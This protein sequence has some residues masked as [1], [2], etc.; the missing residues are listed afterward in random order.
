MA[1]DAYNGYKFW[2]RRVQGAIRVGLKRNCSNLAASED[3]FFVAIDRGRCLRLDPLS[4]RTLTTYT[5]PSSSRT[6]G[7]GWGYVAY[8][9]GLLFGST[10]VRAGISDSVF[11][12]DV[13]TGDRVWSYPGST[14]MDMAIAIGDGK[15][16]F[17]ERGGVTARQ[18]GEA[19]R[20]RTEKLKRLKGDALREAQKAL[21]SADVRQVVALDATTGKTLWTK[22]IDVSNCV[23]ISSGG[24]DLTVMY[25]DKVV[26][27]CGQ[28][29]DGHFWA[30][31]FAGEFSRRS[32]I[33][34]S[35]D[36][37][38]VLWAKKAGYR[39]RPL[40]V[41]NTIIAEPWAFDLH[42]GKPKMRINPI[43]GARE[44]W[45][46]AR[47]GHHCGPM[48]AGA[49]TLAFRS[50]VVGYYDLLND[51]GPFHFGGQRPGCHINFI[52][53]NGLLLIPEGS[54]GCMCPFPT[55]C[56][57]VFEHRKKDR[58]WGGYSAKGPVKPMKHIAIN[59]GAPGDRKDAD[60]LLWLAY[61]RKSGR[62][63]LTFKASI[64][65][66]RLF[67][68][69]P[70][71]LQV[72]GTST[73]WLYTYG[74]QGIRR[75]DVPLV[76]T[77]DGRALYTVRLAFADLSNNSRGKR[78]FDVKIQGKTV[79]R[80]FDVVKEAGGAR[81]AIVKEFPNVKVD[82]KLRVEFVSKLRK[83]SPQQSPILQAMEVRRERVLTLGLTAPSFLLN[84]AEPKQ[85][86]A[87]V[88]ANYKDRAFRGTLRAVCSS[89]FTVSPQKKRLMIA[90]GTKIPVAITV[91]LR[92]KVR[93]GKYPIKIQLLRADGQIECQRESAI[94]Y[95]ADRSRV[96]LKA[97]E[98]AWVRK[99]S[100]GTNYGKQ[101]SLNVDGGNQTMYDEA[102]SIAYI[103]FRLD[104]PG[105][106]LSA[107]LRLFNAGNPSGNAG[108][109]CLVTQPWREHKVTF[110]TRPKLGKELAR[111]GRCS[112]NQTLELPLDLSLKGM[113]ELS[114]AIDATSTDGVTYLSRE[115]R[116]PA[117]LVVEYAVRAPR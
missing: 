56:T 93:R 45:Q 104:I 113:K 69:N 36:T 24:G 91:A 13:N 21:R 97:E 19:L 7:R 52:F 32:I 108:R 111:I 72:A 1:Y 67:R 95:L 71:A 35:A 76:D 55:A 2:K 92:R 60:G 53:A 40:I 78:V 88:I 58:N 82:E 100:A 6:K 74:Y 62:L 3:S 70:D 48:D 46:M 17:V 15:V 18:R 59:F 73:P 85:T 26:V 33:T 10:T 34:L 16:F 8:A 41:K 96:V 4:G 25:R 51:Y 117:E 57:V 77:G 103:K 44:P 14:I 42:T 115:A 94:E 116:K 98:D 11:A 9:N 107:T 23:R 37:G 50:G 20:E 38:R 65:G 12:L 80:N 27:L 87:A 75:L 106:P 39:S 114:L 64:S 5:I 84:N 66:G 110:N 86:G 99:A 30:E 47:P 43:T 49:Y 79:L 102:Y 89:G 31:F 109:I 29:S 22:P 101:G 61:P 83:P 81:K 68:L 54:S 28:P 112:E 63:Q 90:S 105:E